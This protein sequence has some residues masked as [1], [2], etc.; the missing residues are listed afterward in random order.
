[1][2]SEYD[3]HIPPPVTTPTVQNKIRRFVEI[4]AQPNNTSETVVNTQINTPQP[5]ISDS[6]Q[7]KEYKI[8]KSGR[9][10]RA[11]T[12]FGLREEKK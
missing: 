11:P 1:M 9:I 6:D 8:T 10:S 7:F 4:T 2:D 5:V 3:D 12:R